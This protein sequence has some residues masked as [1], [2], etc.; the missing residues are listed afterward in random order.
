MM[1]SVDTDSRSKRVSGLIIRFEINSDLTIK[2]EKTTQ[3]SH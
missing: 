3:K 2:E 1:G